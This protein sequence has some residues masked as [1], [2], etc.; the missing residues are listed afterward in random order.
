MRI[1]KLGTEEFGTF[2]EVENYFYVTLLMEERNPKGKFRLPN[3]NL[4]SENG[5]SVG[6]RIL[7]SY[8]KI[9]CFTA[10]AKAGRLDNNDEYAGKYP[11]YFVVDMSS[12][13]PT[14]ISLE[15]VE[16][17]L[18]DVLDGK[19]IVS[20]RSWVKIPDSSTDELWESIRK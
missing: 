4:I 17:S 9:V 20:A 13:Q 11:Y 15:K 12:V 19:S 7:F 18:R 3:G 2:D 1:I 10:V 5:L 14:N 6:E 16:D 8:K